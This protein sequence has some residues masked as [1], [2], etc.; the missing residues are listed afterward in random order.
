MR[1]S[2]TRAVL[3]A[4]LLL[5][6]A[7]LAQQDQTLARGDG[8]FGGFGGPQFRITRAAGETIGLA[9]G[10]GAFLI[11]RRLAIGGAGFGGTT[12]VDAILE[13][14]PTRGEMDLSY[15][16]L[17]IEL[18][19]YPSRLVHPVVGLL[20]GAGSVSVWPDDLRPRN[21]S[22]TEEFFGVVEPHVGLELN[23][24]KWFRIG[25]MAG[26]RVAIN[27][28]DSRLADS[29]F[30]GASGTLVLRFGAF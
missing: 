7:L 30:N 11:G 16:G 5:P 21:R 20:V 18:I 8:S 1:Q 15:G 9:G 14:S 28:E 24:I 27:A 2:L 3:L 22:G 17:T 4:T 25:A 19:S 23:V 29:G 10:G 12:R 26:Y 13:G 6:S